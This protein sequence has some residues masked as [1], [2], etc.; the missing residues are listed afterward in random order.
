MIVEVNIVF[1][2]RLKNINNL[3]IV[4]IKFY[5]GNIIGNSVK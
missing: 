3:L 1:R 4:N 2:V 5:F